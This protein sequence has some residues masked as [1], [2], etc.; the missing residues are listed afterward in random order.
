MQRSRS[1]ASSAMQDVTANVAVRNHQCTCSV[2]VVL[3]F[4]LVIWSQER[5]YFLPAIVVTP[6]SPVG[7]ALSLPIDML[8]VEWTKRI[9]WFKN[10][11]NGRLK[12]YEPFMGAAS[13]APPCVAQWLQYSLRTQETWVHILWK[14][15][16]SSLYTTSLW[17]QICLNSS[18]FV[19]NNQLN[20]LIFE[21]KSTSK[22]ACWWHYNLFEDPPFMPK[23]L[24][25]CSRLRKHFYYI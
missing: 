23:N 14:S 13:V 10:P 5:M 22:G 11:Q 12:R 20:N 25:F 9:E 15:F 16:S 4:V 18:Y 7:I 2:F 19:L 17:I 24:I 8:R 1:I 6:K 3:A 21:H